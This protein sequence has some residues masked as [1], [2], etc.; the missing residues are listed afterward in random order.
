M[1]LH[2][3]KSHALIGRGDSTPRILTL[4]LPPRNTSLIFGAVW[5]TSY[6]TDLLSNWTSFNSQCKYGL[7]KIRR[8]CAKSFSENFK[9]IEEE[10]RLREERRAKMKEIKENMSNGLWREGTF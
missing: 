4:G 1:F 2:P 9:M 10:G 5:L 3:R 8:I 6:P 7:E